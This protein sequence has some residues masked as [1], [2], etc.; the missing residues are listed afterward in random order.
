MSVTDVNNREPSASAFPWDDFV[1]NE[2][3]YLPFI[4]LVMLG[5]KF[6]S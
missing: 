4:A 1:P 2:L 3:D 6:L 5:I